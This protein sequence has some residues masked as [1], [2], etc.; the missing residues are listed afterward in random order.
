MFL[1]ITD[2]LDSNVRQLRTLGREGFPNV[3]CIRDNA[4]NSL[5]RKVGASRQV[6]HPQTLKRPVQGKGC[7]SIGKEKEKGRDKGCAP[8]PERCSA[9][10]VQGTQ[11]LRVLCSERSAFRAYEA[12]APIDP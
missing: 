5:I 7:Q 12:R 4:L 1:Q 10:R 9:E 8:H 2:G 3:G 6:R 11:S